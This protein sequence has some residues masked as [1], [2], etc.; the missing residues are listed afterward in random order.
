M[1]R[2]C[3]QD[4]DYYASWGK[5]L[6]DTVDLDEVATPAVEDLMEHAENALLACTPKRK[7]GNCRFL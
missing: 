2:Q 7:Q 4:E 3:L 5:G 6:E 1:I